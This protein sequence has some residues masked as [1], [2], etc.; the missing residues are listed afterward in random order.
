[1]NSN[2]AIVRADHHALSLK[3]IEPPIDCRELPTFEAS[4]LEIV[5][6]AFRNAAPIAL[7]QAWMEQ[8]ELNFAPGEVRVGWRSNSILVFAE[9]TDESIFNR[10]TGHN[11][12]TWLHGDTFEIFLRPVQEQTYV[13]LH[14]TPNNYR[15]QLRYPDVEAFRRVK[16][17]GG[18]QNVL[19]RDEAFLSRTWARPEIERWFVYAEIPT[20][21]VCDHARPLSGQQWRFSF[22]RYDYQSGREYPVLSS[23]SAHTEPD[24]HR[25]SEWRLMVFKPLVPTNIDE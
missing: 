18:I 22:S 19:I 2:N 15:L 13:E 24:F 12:Y 17:H 10:V 6:R 8:N 5:R 7:R 3:E 9:L 25:Q 14:I 16:L 11:Q 1:M 23:S 20:R 4:E 21:S